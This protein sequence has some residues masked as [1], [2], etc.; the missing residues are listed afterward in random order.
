MTASHATPRPRPRAGFTLIE[1]LVVIAI[2]AVLIALLLPG[3]AGGPRGGPADPVHQQPQAARPGAAQLSLAPT[4]ASR[5]R[6]ARARHRRLRGTDWGVW[7]A[8]SMLLPYMEQTRGLQRAATSP[9]PTRGRRQRHDRAARRSITTEINAFLCP[10]SSPPSRAV[11]PRRRLNSRRARR[12]T[13]TSPRS[14]RASTSTAARHRRPGDGGVAQRDVRGRGQAIKMA[15]VSDGTSN[16]IAF[17][18]WKTGDFNENQ[19]SVQDVIDVG[20]RSPPARA[21]TSRTRRCPTAAPG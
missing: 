17:S 12:A 16:T 20:R 19:L 14:A 15:G 6:P 8:Q 2:I 5:R 1:L 4:T 7:S 13:T 3:R 11:P 10:S 18:E 21:D 9:S